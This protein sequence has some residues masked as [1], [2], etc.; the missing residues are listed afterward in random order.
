MNEVSNDLRSYKTPGKQNN[1]TVFVEKLD[2]ALYRFYTE[3]L[4]VITVV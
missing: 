3:S 2:E 4:L 1:F